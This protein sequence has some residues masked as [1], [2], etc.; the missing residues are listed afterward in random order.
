MACSFGAMF[1]SSGSCKAACG[2][3]LT[4]CATAGGRSDC[5]DTRKDPTHCG[6]CTNACTGSEVCAA[7]VCVAYIPASAGWECGNGNSFPTPCTLGAQAVCVVG[8]TCP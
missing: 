1:C 5:V 2:S 8:T 6:S 4:G 7:G 3:G